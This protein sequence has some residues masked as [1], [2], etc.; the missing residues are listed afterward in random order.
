MQPLVSSLSAGDCPVHRWR[1]NQPVHRTVP[2]REWRYQRL[3]IYVYNYDVDLLQMSRAMLE[4]CK[5]NSITGLDRPWGFQDVE[6]PRFHNNRHKKVVRLSALSTGR[7]YPQEIILVLIS[8]RSWFDPRAIVRSEGL[9][10]RKTL[11]TPSG[12]E[13]STFRLV[14]KCLNQLRQRVPLE[15]RRGF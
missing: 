2:C 13:P 15:T 4:T 14:A 12:F 10:Q 3:H 11:V 7:L 5:N 1:K 9:R 8:V 6:V